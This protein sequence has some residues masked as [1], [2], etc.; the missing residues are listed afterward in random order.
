MKVHCRRNNK[1]STAQALQL[2]LEWRPFWHGKAH[3]VVA[4]SSVATAVALKQNG[5]Y[6]VGVVKTASKIYP[7]TVHRI[8]PF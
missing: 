1:T 2:L 6:F 3:I 5:A 8:P 7:Q 4:F